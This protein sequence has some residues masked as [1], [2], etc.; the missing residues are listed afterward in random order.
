MK[1]SARH[2]FLSI[3]LIILFGGNVF[4]QQTNDEKILQQI[5]QETNDTIRINLMIRYMRIWGN[6]RD[7]TKLVAEIHDLSIKNNYGPGLM[8]YRFYEGVQLSDQGRYEVAI[9]KVKSAIAG[10]D[11]L[12]IIQPFGSPL[13]F[14]RYIFWKAGKQIE[15]FR[16]YS[17]K[18]VYYK[19]YGPIQNTANCYHGLGQYY[20]SLADYDK[21]IGYFLRALDVD[22]TFDTVG[23]LNEKGIIGGTYLEWGNLD[24][25]EE[26]QLSTLKELIARNEVFEYD[27]YDALGKI[28]FK[29]KDYKKAFSYYFQGKQGYKA[30]LLRA[31]NLVNIAAVHLELANYDSTL[32]YLEIAE[33]IRQKEKSV[34]F[35]AYNF[36]G[37]DYYFFKY[38]AATGN[39]NLA[40][41]HLEAAINQ[42]DSSK[43]IRLLLTYTNEISSFLLKEGDSLQSLRYLVQYQS[44]QDSLNAMN[45]RA[46]IASYEIEQQ[47]QQ[48][49]NE[50]T[51]LQTQ[52]AT[53]R[54][55]YLIGGVF[56]VLLV[57]GFISRMRYKK[58]RDEEH[59]T[60]DFKK[61]LAQAETK[62]LRSQ[63]NPHFIFNCLNSINSL[64]MEEK[65]EIASDYL[66]KFSKLIR[67]I[68]DNSRS[69]TITIEKEL[70][71]LKLYV[72][73][74]SARFDNKF[75]CI[76]EVDKSVN[77]NSIMI[78]PMLLQP[79]VENA[80]WQGQ[81]QK[82][83]EGT[84]TIEIKM[85]GEE[86][87]NI[88]I[89]DDGIGREKAAELKSKSAT[90]KSHGLKVT[91][92]RIEMMNKLNSTGA[93]V[94]IFDLKNE[95]GQATG[96]MVELII[97]F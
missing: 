79:F 88:S 19:K 23:V 81:M 56:L 13:Y 60:T 14:I 66:I 78:P 91:S 48:K 87:L 10:L 73:L 92:Q 47:Q 72:T 33:K 65:H 34:V 89:T 86:S 74:E 82:E 29:R 17:D 58:K 43:N 85:E 24:K 52:K 77:K 42:V 62:A 5:E 41:Q 57:I 32:L 8:Y 15:M 44:L 6:F 59:L 49:E 39:E 26:Y 97:P 12:G 1:I 45:T 50:I 28:Y 94:N 54:N 55:Y 40:L 31:L 96:T 64:V 2:S 76:F 11:S 51:Q 35:F 27:I 68:L 46:R 25:A 37:I 93:R 7:Y 84:I 69:E 20:R 80:I 95:N 53:Q 22:E 71:T 67:L 18:I 36:A 75:K 3:L 63:M 61:Q 90:H 38:Y 21:A 9:N 4:A 16:Y 83:T 70:E 30:S